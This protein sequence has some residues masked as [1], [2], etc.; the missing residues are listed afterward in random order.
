[1]GEVGADKGAGGNQGGCF[2]QEGWCVG[3]AVEG[4]GFSARKSG[5]EKRREFSEGGI[6]TGLALALIV[7]VMSGF[8]VIP[9]GFGFRMVAFAHG[10]YLPFPDSV[11]GEGQKKSWSWVFQDLKGLPIHNESPRIDLR[12]SMRTG[13]PPALLTW[14]L[15]ALWFPGPARPA[16]NTSV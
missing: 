12:L 14:M 8:I 15:S 7:P 1:M 5:G 11:T 9:D 13:S 10:R 16:K 4:G 3:I 2:T 6:L